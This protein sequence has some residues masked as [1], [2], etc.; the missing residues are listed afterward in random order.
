MGA[1]QLRCRREG[2]LRCNLFGVEARRQRR[3]GIIAALVCSPVLAQ[4][5]PALQETYVKLCSGC[6]GA[7]ARGTQQG[8]GLA[9]N[10]SVRRRSAQS[11]RNVIRNGIPAAGMPGF[12]LPA[13]TLDALATLIVSLNASA[14]ESTVRA[15]AP[16]AESSSSAKDN[17]PPA[18]WFSVRARPSVR[19][20]RMWRAK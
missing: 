17:A 19:I 6:H 10:P 9:G 1:A 8:P 4:S 7:D 18:T 2:F 15:I 14:A 13:G 11:V 16:P 20:Y 3:F 5:P 12:D